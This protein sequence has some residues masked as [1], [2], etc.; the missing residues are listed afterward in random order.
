MVA[1]GDGRRKRV[2]VPFEYFT[3]WTN[4]RTITCKASNT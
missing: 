2:R 1:G 4:D 3:A